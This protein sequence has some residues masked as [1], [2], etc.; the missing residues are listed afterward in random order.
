MVLSVSWVFLSVQ[1]QSMDLTS[2]SCLL[3]PRSVYNRKGWY[4][5]IL[6]GTVDHRGHFTDVYVGWPGRV[7]D[8][9]VFANSSLYQRG[10]SGNLL[11]DWKEQIDGKDIPFIILGDP[12]YPLLLWL[13]KAHLNNGHLTREHKLFNYCLSKVRVVV[14]HGYYHLKVDGDPCLCVWMWMSEMY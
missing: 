2:P 13:M 14:E 5:I 7:H 6:Q 1:K 4:S 11:L 8:A 12:A 3:S 10:E 9:R